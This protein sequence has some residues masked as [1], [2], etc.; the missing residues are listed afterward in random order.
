MNTNIELFSLLLS[1]SIAALL[2]AFVAWSVMATRLRHA[3]DEAAENMNAAFQISLT[4]SLEDIQ[5]IKDQHGASRRD[6]DGKIHKSSKEYRD[7]Y[8]QYRLYLEAYAFAMALRKHG[9]AKSKD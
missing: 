1:C 4:N 6:D 7:H 5:S 2:G 9:W 8:P 3:L